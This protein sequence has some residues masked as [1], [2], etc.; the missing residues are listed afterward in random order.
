MERIP[1]QRWEEATRA[2]KG[3]RQLHSVGFA[4]KTCLLQKI[5]ESPVA[6]SE[7]LMT[8][9]IPLTN[10]HYC[11]FISAYVPTLIADPNCKEEFYAFLHSA[12]SN[13]LPTDKLI[14]IG[15]FNARV[16]IRPQQRKIP[17]CRRLN[18]VALKSQHLVNQ[19]GEKVAD[20]LSI[21]PET[22]AA[23]DIS[24]TWSTPCTVQQAAVKSIGYT[25]K[26]HQDWFDNSTPGI[27]NLLQAK[28]KALPAHLSNPQSTVLKAHLNSLRRETQCTLRAME[29]D[30][31][32]NKASDGEFPQVE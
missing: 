13:T 23:L 11:T 32:T 10:N 12:I 21:I 18:C 1:S 6:V 16:V 25:R 3:S 26:R 24:S 28:Y 19:L 17:P 5:P 30:W 22:P 9:W 29:N 4:V 15:D 27:Y 7:R 2:T 31:G 8:W 14:L 20:Q